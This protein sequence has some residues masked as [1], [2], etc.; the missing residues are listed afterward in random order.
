MQVF[1]TYFKIIKKNIGQISIYIGVFLVLAIAFSFS[2]TSQSIDNFTQAKTRVAFINDDEN[3]VLIK[4]FKEYLGNYS[5]YV[6]IENNTKKLQD[7]LFFRDIEYIVRIPKG[8]TVD[9]MAGKDANL[10]KTTVAGSTNSI[11]IDMVVNK[12]FNTTK[13]Y[14]KNNNNITQPE[15]VK[16]VAKDLKIDTKVQI[17]KDNKQSEKTGSNVISFYNYLAYAI[18]SI[19]VLG[20]TS[21]MMV[22]NNRNLRRRTL[23]SPMKNLSLNMQI[24]LGDIIYAISC[25]GFMMVI[26]FVL[27]RQDMFTIN[28]LYYCINSFVFTIMALCMAF[29]VGIF[30]KTSNAQAGIA[31]V[32]GLGLSFISGV[33]VPQEI[34]SKTVLNIAKFT[35]TYWYVKANKAISNLTNFSMENLMPIFQYMLIELGFGAALLSVALV[36]SK[37]KQMSVS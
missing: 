9:I 22:F 3:S 23:C 13:L 26:N 2:S 7:A 37:R 15:L 11:Y 4:G 14:L 18:I 29:L 17:Q 5:V 33:F 8:F 20:V 27:F 16:Q 12:Y 34:L 24:I 19:L 36:M 6:P 25:W 1:K 30:V 28:R 31:N 21:I 10:A 35:P 32:L